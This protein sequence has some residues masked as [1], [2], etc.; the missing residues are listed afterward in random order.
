MPKIAFFP[1]N[2]RGI[3]ALGEFQENNEVL[4]FRAVRVEINTQEQPSSTGYQ[5]R[6]VYNQG[7]WCLAVMYIPAQVVNKPEVIDNGNEPT[8]NVGKRKG[9]ST[10]DKV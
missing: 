10:A 7:T 2:D 8:T 5:R 3:Q 4:N 6:G 9:K 1:L